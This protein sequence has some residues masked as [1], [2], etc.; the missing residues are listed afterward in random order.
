MTDAKICGITTPEAMTAAIDGGARFVGLVFYPKSPRFVDIE[1]ATY[2]ARYVPTGVRAVGLFVD[3]DD[4]TLERTLS[5]VQLDMIQ[6]HGHESPG[7]V[8]EIKHK[9]GLQVIK[10]MSVASPQDLEKVPGYEVAADHLMFDAKPQA[11]DSLPGGN[12]LAFDWNILKGMET[13]HPWF[14]AGGLTPEN[15]LEAITKLSPDIVDVSSGVESKPGVKDTAKI[16]A[17][18]EAV[19]QADAKAA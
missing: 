15:I 3:P 16:A 4:E 2:L 18:L 14:L 1:V 9:F 8:A 6:L 11:S 19:R 12:G 7:R 17:F 5:N 10:A 13:K